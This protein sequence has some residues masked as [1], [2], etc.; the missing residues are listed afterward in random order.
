ME[1]GDPYIIVAYRYARH[2]SFDSGWHQHFRNTSKCNSEGSLK[3]MNA[4]NIPYLDTKLDT[5]D[6]DWTDM[7]LEFLWNMKSSFYF[8]L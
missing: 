1:Y 8:S 4:R 7:K 3:H 6:A 5:D 2:G